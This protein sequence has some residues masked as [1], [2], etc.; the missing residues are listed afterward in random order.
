[1]LEVNA[2]RTTVAFHEHREVTAGLCGL[3]DPKA[4]GMVGYVD[5]GR[6]IAGDLQEHAGIRATFVGL[7]GRMLEARSEA[8][9]GRGPRFVADA[10]AHLGQ[11]S[12]VR[13]IAFDIGEQRHVV[14]RLCAG[15][16]AA[17]MAL[18]ITG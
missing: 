17:E 15:M 6:V 11:R 4:I 14:A 2:Q 10:R 12:C 9:A 3:D 1:M 7:T 5:V 8:E 16:H 13:R 18:Q